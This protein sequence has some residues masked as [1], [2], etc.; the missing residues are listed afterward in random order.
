[1]LSSVLYLGRVEYQGE[2]YEGEHEAIIDEETFNRVREI[3]RHNSATY[4]AHVRNKHGGIL[5]GVLRCAA[6]DAAMTHAT[7]KRGPKRYRYYVC[8]G[9]QKHGW[10]SC[11]NKSIPAQEIEDFVLARIRDIGRD[12]G[13]IGET[14][15][16]VAGLKTERRPD[17]EAEHRRLTSRIE[18]L[19]REGKELVSALGNGN[20][21]GSIVAARLGEIEEGIATSE[22]RATEVREELIA[23]ERETVDEKSLTAALSHFDGVW[24]ALYPRERC[25]VV[26]LLIERI[27]WSREDEMLEITFRPNGIKALAAEALLAAKEK[28]E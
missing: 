8:T 9:A 24:E 3:K 16:Q 28:P 6:C 14:I 17:L 26:S 4:G 1:M 18:K 21:N 10:D 27:E 19:N 12:P 5:K 25:R 15:R 13:V 20:G 22:R 11:P 23:I 2:V 7:S